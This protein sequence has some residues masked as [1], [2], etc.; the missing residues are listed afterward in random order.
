VLGKTAARYA[1]AEFAAF[2]TGLVVNQP[3]GKETG[4]RRVAWRH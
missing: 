2:L 1:S 3:R 4:Q